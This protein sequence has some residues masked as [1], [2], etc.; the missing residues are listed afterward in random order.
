[1]IGIGVHRTFGRPE[2]TNEVQHLQ[3]EVLPSVIT[4]LSRVEAQPVR[5]GRL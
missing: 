4:D 1:M 3:V 2:F 5:D